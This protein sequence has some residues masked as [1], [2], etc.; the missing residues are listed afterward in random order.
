MRLHQELVLGIGGVRAIRALGPGAGGLAPQRGPLRVPARRARPRV[1]RR[2]ARRSTTPGRGS[3]ATACS[4]STRRSRPAT[5]ASTPTSSGAS[6]ARCS[7]RGDVPVERVLDLGLG[8]GRRPRPVRHDRLQPA[9][10]QRRQRGQPAPRRDRQ[11][12]LAGRHRRTRSWASPTASTRRPGSAQ[13]VVE[14]LARHLDADLDRSTPA[15]TRTASG[16]ASS[17]SRP[18]SCGRRTCARSA[19]WR[20]SPAAG[21]A[22]SSPATASRRRSSPRST[23]ALD[24]AIMT[25]GFARR[26]ATYK[27]AGLLF[28]DIDRLARLHLGRRPAGPDHVRRQG[29]PGRPPGPAGHP[30]DLPALALAAAA[31]PRVH[32]RGLRHAR[33]AVPRPGRRRLAQQPAPTARGV[34]ARRA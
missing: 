24:P 13:P 28:T 29:P 6:P 27:R 1:R 9:P 20:S 32:P 7:T 22:A 33:R 34:R 2:G 5:S 18:T 11:R 12:D 21:C 14:L 10:D 3:G 26:F 23:T 8:H 25:I 17:A 16:S 19:S 15:P 31:R 30:G 4:P